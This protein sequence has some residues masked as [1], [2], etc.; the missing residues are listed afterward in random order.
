MCSSSRVD[1]GS[2]DNAFRPSRRA[3]NKPVQVLVM[4]IDYGAFEREIVLPC[5]VDPDGV[6]AEKRDGLLWIFLPLRCQA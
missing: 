3:R 2:A 4:E 1:C 6:T 5:D